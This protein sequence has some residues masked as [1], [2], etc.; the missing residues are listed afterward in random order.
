MINRI[1]S[2]LPDLTT[3]NAMDDH[4][5]V[6]HMKCD[7]SKGTGNAAAPQVMEDSLMQKEEWTLDDWAQIYEKLVRLT[8]TLMNF[9]VR[10][11][12]NMERLLF[13]C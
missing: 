5:D 10:M 2:F 9:D 4:Q 3:L 1:L 6:G 11:V 7:H 13:D 8:K 12:K